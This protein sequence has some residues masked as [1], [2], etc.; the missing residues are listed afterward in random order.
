MRQTCLLLVMAIMLALAGCGGGGDGDSDSADHGDMMQAGG[1]HGMR[2][3]D[4]DGMQPGDADG[5]QPGDGDGMQPGD[6][7]GMQPGDGDG[8]QPGDMERHDMR[9][10]DMQM[11]Y[12]ELEVE[13]LCD[14]NQGMFRYDALLYSGPPLSSRPLLFNN[15]KLRAAG[16]VVDFQQCLLTGSVAG[17]VQQRGWSWDWPPGLGGQEDARGL[18]TAIYGHKFWRDGPTPDSEIPLQVSQILQLEALDASFEIELMAPDSKHILR[19][20][21]LFYGDYPTANNPPGEG[22]VVANV[23]IRL[24]EPTD[25]SQETT[26]SPATFGGYTYNVLHYPQ[27]HPNAYFGPTTVLVGRE[28]QLS[29]T[30]DLKAV[31]QEMVDRGFVLPQDYLG[32]IELNTLVFEGAGEVWV[33]EYD[34]EVVD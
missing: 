29:G 12:I 2:P 24:D 31:L 17:E 25:W 5:M 23:L 27:G 10:G 21:L 18:L 22:A 26:E 32:S 8:M 30:I 34:I 33:L 16:D 28:S 13:E 14:D 19:F 20:D 6:G 4:A 15:V 3:G 7:D 1:G 9:S 11:D